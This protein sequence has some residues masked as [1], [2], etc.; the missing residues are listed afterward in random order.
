MGSD[1]NRYFSRMGARVRVLEG[2]STV[3]R[4]NGFASREDAPR[5]VLDIRRDKLGEYYEIRTAPG[6][7]QEIVVLN[8]QTMVFAWQGYDLHRFEAGLGVAAALIRDGVADRHAV[9]HRCVPTEPPQ[10]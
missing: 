6:G 8:V 1:L 7:K 5:I 9:G 3:R 10:G 2:V 4:W